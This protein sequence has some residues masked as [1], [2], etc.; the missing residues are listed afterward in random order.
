MISEEL[1]SLL[2]CPENRTPVREAD[3]ALVGRLN[4]RIAKGE[5]RNRDDHVVTEPLD[6]GLVREDG[7]VLYPVRQ[8]IP[9]MLI[10]ESISLEDDHEA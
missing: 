10:G 5:L 8:D 1:L 9:V 4:A 2:V 3:S 6:G 7:A